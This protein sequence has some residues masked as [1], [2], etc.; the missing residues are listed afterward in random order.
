MY[1]LS[2]ETGAAGASFITHSVSDG[3]VDDYFIPRPDV[4]QS[5]TA[6]I[7]AMLT[8]HE[9]VGFFGGKVNGPELGGNVEVTTDPLEKLSGNILLVKFDEYPLVYV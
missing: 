3:P 9:W 8:G 6:T 1:Q 7:N 2:P 5:N 4:I